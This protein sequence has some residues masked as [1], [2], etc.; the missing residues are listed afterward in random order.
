MWNSMNQ[1]VKNKTNNDTVCWKLLE[2]QKMWIDNTYQLS[3]SF[4]TLPLWRTHLRF[5][6]FC[7][8]SWITY[9]YLISYRYSYILYV[10][11]VHLP[12]FCSGGRGERGGGWA[13]YQIFKNGRGTGLTGPRG[14]DF[15]TGVGLQCYKKNKK[16]N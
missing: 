12:P 5:V 11:S 8:V 6:R 13:S 4:A 15:S 3:R 7:V 9:D 16:T 10:H 1:P 14:G 2:N